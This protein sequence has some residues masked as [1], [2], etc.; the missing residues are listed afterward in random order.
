MF[1]G[2]IDLAFDFPPDADERDTTLA[3]LTIDSASSRSLD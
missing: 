2:A 1:A 3:S